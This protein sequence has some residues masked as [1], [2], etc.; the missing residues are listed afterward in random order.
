MVAS[1]NARSF[2]LKVSSGPLF[3]NA[4]MSRKKIIIKKHVL[5]PKHQVLSEKER[6]DLFERYNVSIKELPKI[7]KSDPAIAELGAKLGDVIK[8]TRES[9]TAGRTVFY[10]GVI[11]E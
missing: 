11:N 6:K 4:K 7:L 8:I 3:F 5:V 9:A 2:G 10:R 1:S